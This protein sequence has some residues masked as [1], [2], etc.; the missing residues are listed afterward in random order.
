MQR[1]LFFVD[2]LSTWAGKLFAWSVVL[3]TGVVT[4]EVFMRYVL[5]KPTAWAYDTAYILYGA[6]FIMAGA[7]ALSQNGHVRGDVLYRLFPVRMQASIDLVLYFIFFFPGI[8]ALIYSGYGFA[9]MSWM[10]GERSSFSP[11]GP[12][13]YHFKSLIPLAGFFLLLQGLAE[14]VRCIQA[15]RSGEWPRRLHDVEE[16]EADMIEEIRHHQETSEAARP[17][18]GEGGR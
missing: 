15:I 7:Y 8:L 14:V 18:T 12:P 13:L 11:G 9:R 5:G 16:I 6:L 10:M 17:G 2:Q 4:Y 3:L 1:L